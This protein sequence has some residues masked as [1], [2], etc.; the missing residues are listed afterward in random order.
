MESESNT[1]IFTIKFKTLDNKEY[2][3]DID[4]S[5]TV[6]DLKQKIKEKSGHDEDTQRL[7]YKAKQLKDTDIIENTIINNT[8]I[9]LLIKQKPSETNDN[10]E[11]ETNNT[12]TSQ[13]NN[14][15]NNNNNIFGNNTNNPFGGLLSNILGN[16]NNDD[17]TLIQ[18]VNANLND[19]NLNEDNLQ[20][21]IGNVLNNL[22]GNMRNRNNNSQQNSTNNNANNNN[23]TNNNT[24]HTN[25]NTNNQNFNINNNTSNTGNNGNNNNDYSGLFE[26]FYNSSHVHLN[27]FTSNQNL[28]Q[29]IL[30]NFSRGEEQTRTERIVDWI[31]T[32]T[33]AMTH[34]LS[35]LR[36]ISDYL[37]VEHEIRNPEQRES[38][39]SE[40]ARLVE[41]SR[42]ASETSRDVFRLARS[43]KIGSEPN[44]VSVHPTQIQLNTTLISSMII[45]TNLN[46]RNNNITSN[47]NANTNT[48]ATNNNSHTNN[49][50]NT[51]N[52]PNNTNLNN[53]VNADIPQENVN[54]LN[55]T[56][57]LNNNNNRINNIEIN[58][59]NN[60]HNTNPINLT[61]LN[62]NVN[63]NNFFI[64]SET[65]NHNNLVTGGN[66]ENSRIRE[67][68]GDE[69]PRLNTNQISNNSAEN[70]VINNVEE[71]RDSQNNRNEPII[72]INNVLREVSRPE[73]LSSMMGMINNMMGSQDTNGEEDISGNE[74]NNIMQNMMRNMMSGQGGGLN[75]GSLLGNL[76]NSRPN[77]SLN[78]NPNSSNT[79]SI[80]VN[81]STAQSSNPNSNNINSNA[82]HSHSTT[83]KKINKEKF[84]S[85]TKNIS[86]NSLVKLIHLL[87][88]LLIDY[89]KFRYANIFR[90]FGQM[91]LYDC[92]VL[93]D[94]NF[95]G[96]LKIR[97]ELI[98]KIKPMELEVVKSQTADFIKAHLRIDTSN[99][100][101]EFN[102]SDYSL[103]TV[104]ETITL[105]TSK[106]IDLIL[107]ENIKG[108]I[109]ET[110]LFSILSHM[111]GNLYVFLSKNLVNSGDAAREALR[112]GAYS[113]LESIIGE[114]F[115]EF[116]FLDILENDELQLLDQM[117]QKLIRKYF[118][119]EDGETEDDSKV[120]MNTD[121]YKTFN[122][123]FI[124]N[125][126][127]IAEISNKDKEK[128]F[129]K[130]EGLSSF[131]SQTSQFK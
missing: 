27:N 44:S 68:R 19:G 114:S 74:M 28:P 36:R 41:S 24:S 131:Y 125:E 46:Q 3:I 122:Y 95:Q 86:P 17:G 66:T 39:T 14:S 118:N 12:N 23:T 22:G 62:D 6:K 30:N 103:S 7:I 16:F 92:T 56:Q 64:R 40:M 96:I 60:I 105:Y 112:E 9:H 106:L 10:R 59:S 130:L 20:S 91:S 5:L 121:D 1:S 65:N 110:K 109:F 48:T 120:S 52:P 128:E 67:V 73:N 85:T 84:L 8:C 34:Y 119:D 75:L 81:T 77:A 78:T 57:S 25:N 4:K 93:K 129:T 18:V 124:F 31:R 87:A 58:I 127:V 26:E 123:D 100:L 97:N 47:N 43:L 71:N 83:H 108:K 82:R 49:N 32:Y 33:H 107:D 90:I 11:E 98:S 80:P 15:Q 116:L 101:I 76:N 104:D 51:Q 89:T 53:N 2:T 21:I 54:D 38:L 113:I 13:N 61:N 35:Q 50:N 45:P 79:S 69:R 72:N 37:A 70:N 117:I 88:T 111:T 99:K 94:F 63:N 102:N 42:L 55:S 29:N 115:T 126:N